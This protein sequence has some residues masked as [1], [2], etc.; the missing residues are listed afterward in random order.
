M[1]ELE[2]LRARVPSARNDGALSEI[3]TTKSVKDGS[4]TGKTAINEQALSP[5][6]DMITAALDRMESSYLVEPEFI[7]GFWESG[8]FHFSSIR[9][10]EDEQETVIQVHGTWGRVLNTDRFEDTLLFVN[11]WNANNVWPK[12]YIELET[13]QNFIALFGEVVVDLGP[14]INKSQVEHTVRH[15][16]ATSLGLFDQAEEE[17]PDARALG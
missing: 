15:G 9:D 13:E 7:S 14:D 3:E 11:N 1:E 5:I 16:I 2:R 6:T 17:F 12:A 8:L 10:L 4:P